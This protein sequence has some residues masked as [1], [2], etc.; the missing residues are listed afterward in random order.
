MHASYVAPAKAQTPTADFPEREES[1]KS[2]YN[3]D[4]LSC[5]EVSENVGKQ[6]VPEPQKC[7][8]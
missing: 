1:T 8:Q 7:Q 3:G 5:Q 4:W 6:Q 2:D